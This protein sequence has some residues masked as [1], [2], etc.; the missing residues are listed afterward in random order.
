MIL[1]SNSLADDLG[2]L[3]YTYTVSFSNW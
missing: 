3:E 2:T 1:Y